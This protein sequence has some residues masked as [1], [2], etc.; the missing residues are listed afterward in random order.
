MLNQAVPKPIDGESLRSRSSIYD[1][2]VDDPDPGEPQ[3][4]PVVVLPLN[5]NRRLDREN[6]MR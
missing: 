6:Q 1:T 2:R 5:N 4:P 3:G